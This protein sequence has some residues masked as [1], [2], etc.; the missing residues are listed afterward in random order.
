MERTAEPE[1]LARV[2]EEFRRTFDLHRAIGNELEFCR[3]LRDCGSQQALATLADEAE[4]RARALGNGLSEVREKIASLQD[5]RLRA[6]MEARYLN[7]HTFDEIADILYYSR[8]HVVRL[9]KKALSVIAY[10]D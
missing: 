4:L 10:A 3:R 1:A 9:H 5:G 7:L 6:V 2:R 8:R